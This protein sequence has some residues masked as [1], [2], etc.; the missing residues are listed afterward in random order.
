MRRL[1]L[2]LQT[3]PVHITASKRNIQIRSPFE[4]GTD[5]AVYLCNTGPCNRT[6]FLNRPDKGNALNVRLL[7]TFQRALEGMSSNENLDTAFLTGEGDNFC[8]GPDFQ[9]IHDALLENRPDKADKL[10]Y[11]IQNLGYDLSKL[12]INMAPIYHGAA[13]GAGYALGYNLSYRFATPTTIFAQPETSVGLTLDS[14]ASYFLSKL[15]PGVDRFVAL[16]GYPIKGYDLI[17]LGL[18]TGYNTMPLESLEQAHQDYGIREGVRSYAQLDG[19]HSACFPD[20]EYDCELAE[21]PIFPFGVHLPTIRRC[22]TAESVEEIIALLQEETEDKEF[23]QE[24]VRRLTTHSPLSL[25]IT[26]ALLNAGKNQ[27]LV[28]CLRQEYRAGHRLRRTA[29]FKRALDV[30]MAKRSGD[31]DQDTEVIWD[32]EGLKSV[33]EDQVCSFFEPLPEGEEL[34]LFKVDRP[35]K[36]DRYEVVGDRVP[37]KYF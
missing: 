9:N 11:R 21:K 14:G 29:D 1:A 24:C 26:L 3:Q 32:N 34:V 2:S 7:K 23:A 33:T 15:S 27:S 17:P 13:L 4:R 16:T 30:M 19:I 5:A 36:V 18:A 37:G 28:E 20:H 6:V 10:Y 22:F 31:L 8:L 12:S 35:P 25:Q